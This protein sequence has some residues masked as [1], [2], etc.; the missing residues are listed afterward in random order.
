MESSSKL[1]GAAF[2]QADDRFGGA[3]PTIEQIRH[4]VESVLGVAVPAPDAN[5]IGLGAN[6]ME[7][8]RIINRIEDDSGVR[9][10][11]ENLSFTPSV[12]M[13]AACVETARAGSVADAGALRAHDELPGADGT[14]TRRV[15]PAQAIGAIRDDE[16]W[17][18]VRLMAGMPDELSVGSVRAFRETQ[19][20]LDRVARLLSV[21]R[22]R[23][24]RA[25]YAS[26]GARYPVQTYL[27]A[28][29]GAVAGL[30]CG[31]YYFH[32]ARAELWLLAP[33]LVID[34][35]LYDPLH[36][37]A[38]HRGAAFSIHLVSRPTAIEPLYG[39]RA[40]DYCLLEAGA[41]AQLLRM[42][43]PSYDLGLCAI[44][45][46]DFEPVRGWFELDA[47]QECL[48]SLLGGG[49]P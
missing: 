15:A 25:G 34:A 9:I 47:D 39:A 23:Q 30:A 43:A 20:E 7:L 46:F 36:N 24:A 14:D 11:F 48:H 38:I 10:G 37:A 41:M 29:A 12:A 16:G 31:L 18:V 4:I 27:Y 32:P 40:R 5:I 42:R 8:V 6:S 3:S 45:D 33:D 26:A 17:P 49:A 28:R 1:P 21:L 19:V 35:A 13:L 44:G 2:E 22:Q